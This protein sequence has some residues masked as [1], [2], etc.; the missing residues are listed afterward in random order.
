MRIR[1]GYGYGI[2]RTAYYSSIFIF[3]FVRASHRST[4]ASDGRF[5]AKQSYVR[6][7]RDGENTTSVAGNYSQIRLTPI[8]NQRKKNDEKIITDE[9]IGAG[10]YRG[11]ELAGKLKN[12]IALQPRIS[13]RFIR[14]LCD[15]YALLYDRGR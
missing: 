3:T 7:L 11:V 8:S 12:H 6:L 14:Y 15:C 10:V 4:S 13:C 5:R 2:V 1:S 9:R